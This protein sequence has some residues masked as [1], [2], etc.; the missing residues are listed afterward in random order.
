M[1][2]DLEDKA[3]MLNMYESNMADLSSKMHNLKKTLE[4][5]DAEI[6]QLNDERQRWDI[7]LEGRSLASRAASDAGGLSDGCLSDGGEAGEEG[8]KEVKKKKKPWKVGGGKDGFVSLPPCGW[9]SQGHLTAACMP[10]CVYAVTCGWES[11]WCGVHTTQG[12]ICIQGHYGCA[13]VCASGR[14][15]CV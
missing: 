2:K 3:R 12:P 13:S 7:G 11:C 9:S 1:R 14:L 6:R 5:K 4:E 8:E 10:P 15:W